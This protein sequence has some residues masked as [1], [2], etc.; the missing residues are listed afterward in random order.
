MG[1]K[2][3]N[4]FAYRTPKCKIELQQHYLQKFLLCQSYSET[5]SPINGKHGNLRV[6]GLGNYSW[7]TTVFRSSMAMLLRI[8][9]EYDGLLSVCT[10]LCC[11]GYE[12]RTPAHTEVCGC[13]AV[14]CLLQRD[15]TVE[16]Q[17]KDM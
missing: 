11:H 8:S 6:C 10:L 14:E 17:C 7:I 1:C 13:S 15:K 4:S 5:A 16:A 12:D 3:S 9:P 2:T